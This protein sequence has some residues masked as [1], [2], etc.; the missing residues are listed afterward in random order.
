[1]SKFLTKNPGA[2]INACNKRLA[3]LLDLDIFQWKSPFRV[4]FGNGSSALSTVILLEAIIG[5]TVIIDECAETILSIPNANRKGYTFTL[6]GDMRCVISN[7]EGQP[8][9]LFVVLTK[10]HGP[11]H[12]SQAIRAYHSYL[13]GYGHFCEYEGTLDSIG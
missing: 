11:Q 5:R 6:T 2:N 1:L 7:R 8:R 13:C 10:V 12:E 4:V 9:L 3:E